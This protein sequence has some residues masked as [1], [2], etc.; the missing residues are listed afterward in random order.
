MEIRGAGASFLALEA[1][2][3]LGVRAWDRDRH[4]C[5]LVDFLFLSCPF[6][7]LGSLYNIAGNRPVPHAQE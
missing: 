3:S 7:V 2:V 5:G 1:P 6:L 4:I